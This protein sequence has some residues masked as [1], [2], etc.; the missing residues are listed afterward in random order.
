MWKLIDSKK[1]DVLK[2]TQDNLE[3]TQKNNQLLTEFL[4]AQLPKK[5]LQEEFA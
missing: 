4:E 3:A 2:M 1:I 5:T